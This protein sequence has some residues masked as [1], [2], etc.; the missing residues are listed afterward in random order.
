MRVL[1]A[2]STTPTQKSRSI[3]LLAPIL[4]VVATFFAAVILSVFPATPKIVTVLIEQTRRFVHIG[5]SPRILAVRVIRS[6][7]VRTVE[8]N[9][10]TT[11]LS[12]EENLKTLYGTRVCTHV[13]GIG[14]ERFG[15]PPVSF[16]CRL[17]QVPLCGSSTTAA[18]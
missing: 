3:L 15:N 7:H 9:I 10:R 6:I 12:L 4:D 18:N 8:T 1:L 16:N 17:G 2:L 5:V 11:A 13:V 14:I